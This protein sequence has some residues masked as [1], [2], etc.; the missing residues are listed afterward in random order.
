MSSSSEIPFLYRLLSQVVQGPEA[1]PGCRKV[2]VLVPD[3]NVA[4]FGHL[5]EE[6]QEVRQ[7]KR[8]SR[9]RLAPDGQVAGMIATQ[10]PGEVAAEL[11]DLGIADV[12]VEDLLQHRQLLRPDQLLVVEKSPIHDERAVGHVLDLVEHLVPHC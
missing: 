3:G 12:G 10:D 6:I 5:R 2:Q 1:R 4:V 7:R 11:L 9:A 8:L